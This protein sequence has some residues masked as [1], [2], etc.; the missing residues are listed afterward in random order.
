MPPPSVAL[1]RAVKA[2][3]GTGHWHW[4]LARRL[5]QE[6]AQP[7]SRCPSGRL[8]VDVFGP[9]TR[10]PKPSGPRAEPARYAVHQVQLGI[11]LPEALLATAEELIK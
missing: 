8:R 6:P 7:R 3:I 11:E 4:M 2:R 1:P 5:A 9:S 10:K